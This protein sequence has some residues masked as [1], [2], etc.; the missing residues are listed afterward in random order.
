M[1]AR[2]TFARWLVALVL[3]HGIVV[4][5]GFFAPYDPVE[6]DRKSPYL[7]PM[8]FH[9]VDAHGHLHVRPFVYSLRLRE[10]SF[11]QY[12][13]DPAQPHPL[14]FFLPGAR[15]RLLG[16]LPCRM[17]L[18]GAEGTRIY[19]LGS[20]A[21]GRDQLSRFL[22][23]GQVSLAA[24]L[25]GAG[26]TLF[27]GLCI[28]AVAGYYGGWSDNVLMRLAELFLALP[29]LYLLFALRAFLPLAVSPLEAFFLI[30][31][32][33]GAVGWARP[34]RLVRGVVLSAKERDFVRAARG[35]GATNG[36][37]LRRHIL[38]ETSSVLLTQAAILIPQ[39]VLAEMAFSFLGLGVP[40][41]LPSWGNLLSSLQQYSVLVSYWWMYLPSLIMVPFFL[42]YLGL[43]S[44]L[45]EWGE[46]YKIDTRNLGT[47]T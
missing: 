32:V 47:L 33:I 15:Y 16:F 45:Q 7:P 35:F 38:P 12:E 44:S 19:F 20:D 39:F 17:H 29:W 13:E 22:V 25:L 11:D 5:A 23:G 37:L 43:A 21:Y 4:F 42:G 31:A 1:R 24:G 18:F 8:R 41:P 2:R 40:E 30:I 3:L 26:L 34:A 27:I 10:G 36:Y 28:G 9:L 6:Q 14:K 46:A